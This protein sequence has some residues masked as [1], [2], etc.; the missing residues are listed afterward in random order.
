MDR[1][2]DLL[3][4][5]L[6]VGVIFLFI[7]LG[8]QPAFAKVEPEQEN[9][10][11]PKDY[12]F[13]TI[14]D[15]ANNPDVKELLEQYNH[16]LFTSDY[17]YKSVY[18][19]LLLKNPRLLYSML[20]TRPSI[21]IEY[22]DKCYNKGIEVTKIIGEDKALEII[23]VNKITDTRVFDELNNII[24]NDKELSGKIAIL[25]VIKEESSSY[26]TLGYFPVFCFVLWLSMFVL[27]LIGLPFNYFVDSYWTDGSFPILAAICFIPYL[28]LIFL[29]FVCWDIGFMM[30]CFFTNS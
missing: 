14:I 11:E 15:I 19:Q 27:I 12:L 1:N 5:S 24:M 8:I 3:Y 20:F 17:D 13:Q 9:D 30:N 21:T 22:L 18:R 2:P 6:V 7:G 10:V 29:L 26:T 4:K 25:K 23:E 28:I 16:Q